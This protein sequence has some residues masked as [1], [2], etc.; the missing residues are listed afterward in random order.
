MVYYWLYDSVGYPCDLTLAILILLITCLCDF[1]SFCVGGWPQKS[2]S[3]VKDEIS[4]SFF[5]SSLVVTRE[6]TAQ[7]ALSTFHILTQ[8]FLRFRKCQSCVSVHW[9]VAFLLHCTLRLILHVRSK[10]DGW[11]AP[12]KLVAT[13]TEL[14]MRKYIKT[15]VRI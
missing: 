10:R 13:P 1:C 11:D 3:R 9:T 15:R 12:T 8:Q 6:K 5:T 14:S 4:F 2:S 7:V